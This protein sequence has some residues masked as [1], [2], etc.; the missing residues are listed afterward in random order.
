MSEQEKKIKFL[1]RV[2]FGVSDNPQDDVNPHNDLES[3]GQSLVGEMRWGVSANA[4]RRSKLRFAV[5]YYNVLRYYK[6]T[7]PIEDVFENLDDE[8][9]NDEVVHIWAQLATFN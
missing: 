5:N 2:Y 8:K 9:T 3:F 6:I 1:C 7:L 4:R